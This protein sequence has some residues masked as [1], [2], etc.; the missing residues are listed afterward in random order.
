MKVEVIKLKKNPFD[1]QKQK[2]A[3]Q[4]SLRATAEGA[5][6]DFMVTTKTWSHQPVFT[7]RVTPTY[8]QVSTR[9]RVYGW[10]TYGTESHFIYPRRAKRLVFKGGSSPKT[11]PGVIRSR[12]GKSGSGGIIFARV[13]R[14]PG[15]AP[16]LF[17]ETIKE[18][19]GKQFKI[20]AQRAVIAAL[21]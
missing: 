2:L 8:S 11:S 19:W 18:K 17:H 12:Q 15:T 4:N 10:V 13:V 16:R 21:K 3:I 6:A 14:H 1:A 9:D 20:I 5:K 7:I